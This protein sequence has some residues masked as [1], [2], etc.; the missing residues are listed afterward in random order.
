MKDYCTQQLVLLDSID[1]TL[2]DM[3]VQ[4]KYQ[5]LNTLTV[6]DVEAELLQQHCRDVL[7]SIHTKMRMLEL[8]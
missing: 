4:A 6:V 8:I 3:L 1:T 7:Q 2:D 5:P